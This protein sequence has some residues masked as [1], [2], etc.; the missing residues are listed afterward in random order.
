MALRKR[1]GIYHCNF[2]MNRQR[3]RRTLET[4]D[5]REATN[6]ENEKKRL[7]GKGKLASGVTAA[8]SRLMFNTALIDTSL[9]WPG[10]GP[11]L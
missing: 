8:F 7:A 11:R 5:W 9:N 1:N 6:K 3:F 10:A 4:S 2:V